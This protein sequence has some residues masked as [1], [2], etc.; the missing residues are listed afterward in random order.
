LNNAEIERFSYVA[1]SGHREVDDHVGTAYRA[2]GLRL[3]ANSGASTLSDIGRFF[4]AAARL[5]ARSP[6]RWQARAFFTLMGLSVAMKK[7]PLVAR[8]R[9]PLV[10]R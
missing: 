3:A 5:D 1:F 10:A 2:S 4:G 9:S 8:S 6:W 7:S